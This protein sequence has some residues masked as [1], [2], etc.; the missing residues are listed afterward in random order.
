MKRRTF[1]KNLAIFLGRVISPLFV[2]RI[3]LGEKIDRLCKRYSFDDSKMVSNLLGGS[4][5]KGIVPKEY[6]GSPTLVRFEGLEVY[7]L[8]DPHSY[9]KSMYG[10]YMQLPPVE[11]QVSLHDYIECNLEKS[12]LEK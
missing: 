11:K 5:M 3:N 12:Y 7:G 1:S 9:L 10:D 4:A 2:K 8:E 6:F